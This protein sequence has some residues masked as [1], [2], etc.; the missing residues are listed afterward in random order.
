M[1][2]L[3]IESTPLSFFYELSNFLFRT[4][5]CHSQGFLRVGFYLFMMILMSLPLLGDRDPPLSLL[6]SSVRPSLFQW[7]PG[8]VEAF[9]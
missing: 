3:R 5:R 6:A 4:K 8:V 1:R 7:G 2:P 9:A